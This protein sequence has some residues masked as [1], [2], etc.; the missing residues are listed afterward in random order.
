[1][2]TPL[3][4]LDQ[5]CS[6]GSPWLVQPLLQADCWDAVGW[7]P[8]HCILSLTVPFHR[9][10]LRQLLSLL[11]LCVGAAAQTPALRHLVL[12]KGEMHSQLGLFG[13]WV[14][15]TLMVTLWIMP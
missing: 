14:S 8:A 12:G 13:A 6:F 7:G 11:L 3:C 4:L 9:S 15:V 1:M 2:R 5:E 10:S